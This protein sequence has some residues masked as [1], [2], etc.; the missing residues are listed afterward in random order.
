[1][2]MQ[3]SLLGL[4]SGNKMLSLSS[5]LNVVVCKLSG[6]PTAQP[7][8]FKAVELGILLAIKMYKKM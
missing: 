4:R 8:C 5:V 1:M 6:L 3:P 7:H 2:L